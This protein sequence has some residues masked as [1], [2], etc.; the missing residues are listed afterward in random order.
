[1]ATQSN[2]SASAR[3]VARGA[4]LEELTAGTAVPVQDREL[5]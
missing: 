3:M 1:M 5:S 2:G 4:S